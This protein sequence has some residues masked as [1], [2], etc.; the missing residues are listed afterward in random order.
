MV[1]RL[2]VQQAK[3]NAAKT[4]GAQLVIL[5]HLIKMMNAHHAYKMNIIQMKIATR[6]H[7]DD[8]QLV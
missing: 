4:V 7:V 1:M 2:P 6:K 8:V 5:N 3:T